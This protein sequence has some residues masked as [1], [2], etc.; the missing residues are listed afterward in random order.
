MFWPPAPSDIVMHWQQ[1]YELIG[2]AVMFFGIP[3]LKTPAARMSCSVLNAFGLYVLWT[4]GF[5][6]AGVLP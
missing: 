5:F 3:L 6:T 4:G 2:F 1:W